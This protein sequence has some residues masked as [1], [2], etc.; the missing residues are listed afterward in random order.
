MK[1]IENYPNS[2]TRF[3][4]PA[5][6]DVFSEHSCRIYSYQNDPEKVFKRCRSIIAIPAQDEESYIASCLIALARQTC[7]YN[8]GVVLLLNNCTDQTLA[9]VRCLSPQL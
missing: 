2:N 4:K 3:G 7:R 6:T 5:S 8:Y 1:L 9:V